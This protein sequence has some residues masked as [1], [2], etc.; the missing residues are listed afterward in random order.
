M[1]SLGLIL[2]VLILFGCKGK[3]DSIQDELSK[4][5]LDSVKVINDAFNAYCSKLKEG[6]FDSNYL[7]FLDL[8]S[9]SDSAFNINV[10]KNERDVFENQV[11]YKK[12]RID[13]VRFSK[14][15]QTLLCFV[16]STY[17]IHPRF[18]SSYSESWGEESS[19]SIIPVR[20][21]SSGAVKFKKPNKKLSVTH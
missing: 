13:S 17:I 19:T 8:P 2:I 14:I 4:A 7:A 18:M 20:I 11:R 10:L 3:D 9:N 21:D 5:S 15:K 1:R 12:C 16:S 6:N